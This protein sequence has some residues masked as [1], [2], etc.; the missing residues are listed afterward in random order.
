LNSC[1]IFIQGTCISF[2]VDGKTKANSVKGLIFFL[3]AFLIGLL[4]LTFVKEDLKRTKQE[5]TNS[6]LLG[7]DGHLNN[8]SSSP[9]VKDIV[10]EKST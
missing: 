7:I 6:S 1:L 8:S 9:H 5:R 4:L 3:V 10:L 2:V